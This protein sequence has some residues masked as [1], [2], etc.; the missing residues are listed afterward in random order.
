MK[1]IVFSL[2]LFAS[3]FTSI[4]QINLD[5]LNTKPKKFRVGFEV[6]L[7]FSSISYNN[8]PFSVRQDNQKQWTLSDIQSG[9][10][11]GAQPS[12][13]IGLNTEWRITKK[14]ALQNGLSLFLRDIT[15]P[16]INNQITYAGL[17]TMAKI[18]PLNKVPSLYFLAGGR[19]DYMF[20]YYLGQSRVILNYSE[21]EF[22]LSPIVGVGYEWKNLPFITLTT[23][24]RFNQGVK[25]LVKN[26]NWQKDVNDKATAYNQTIWLNLNF[27]FKKRTKS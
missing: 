25:N 27:W 10:F 9:T 19:L 17:T 7:T 16:P 4:A 21:K 8:M 23:D 15:H 5:K 18:S 14:I 24:I 3:F 6:G 11:R 20:D 12:F 1:K 13:M 22:E 2:I 26:A